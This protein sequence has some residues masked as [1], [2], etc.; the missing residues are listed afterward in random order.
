MENHR[1]ISLTSTIG[2]TMERTVTNHLRNFAESVTLLTEYQAVI[3][4]CHCTEDQ[5]L[6]LSQTISDGLQQSPMQRTVLAHIDYR[7][8]YDIV[9]KD[10]SLSKISQNGIPSHMARRIHIGPLSNRLTWITFHGARSPAI[11]L[12]Q[13]VP[14]PLSAASWCIEESGVN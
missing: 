9:R 1:P 2:N 7:R 14:H 10:A 5:L 12:T 3:K 4:H 13:G 6:R 11:T 8:A